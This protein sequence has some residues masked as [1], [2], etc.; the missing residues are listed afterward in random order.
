MPIARPV[1]WMDMPM[2]SG[3]SKRAVVIDGSSLTIDQVVGVARSRGEVSLG[4][5]AKKRMMSS[6][7][8]LE[9]LLEAGTTIYAVNTGV[10]DLVSSRIP[11]KDLKALQL[12][13]LRSHACGVG[14]PYPEEITRAIMLLRANALAKGYSGV[15]P[16]IADALLGML[17]AGIHP[18]IPR[19]GSVGASG[20][21]TMLAHL[22]LVL[23][24]EGFADSGHGME[25]GK[26]ALA[27]KGMKPLSLEAKEAISIINGTQAMTAIG[28][29]AVRDAANLADNAQI[30]A[31]LSLEAL[32]G[33]SAAFDPRISKVRAYPG[34]ARVAEN[35]ISLLDGS[36]IMLSHKHCSKVQDAYTLRCIPQV[37]GASLGAIWYAEDIVS[38]EINSATDNPLFFPEDSSVVSAGNFHGQPVALAMDF[39][40]LAVHEIGSFAERRVARMVDHKLS[41]LPAFLTRH[42]GLSSG[43]M[44]PQYVAASLVSENKVL[45]HPASASSIPTSANQEDHNS[46]GTIA[47]WKAR[48]ILA[49]STRIVAIEMLAA[50]QA[51][52]F[53]SASSSEV[54]EEVRASIREKVPPLNEDRSMT[55]DI[56]ALGEMIGAGV[57]ADIAEH[58]C[59]F[60][61]A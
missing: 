30:A 37:L 25:P 33:T 7:A 58:S 23:V 46:M 43:M 24:G 28:A 39:M 38:V 26:D 61:R 34:Q 21:L 44:V 2:T 54:L 47:A 31:A 4:D 1:H 40:G 32:K 13:L 20:D 60:R 27:R 15:R 50:A 10:G 53:V 45:V 56:E 3:E 16:D 6:R 42:G 48:Q 9:K 8:A 22:G 57:L 49:N 17:N 36:E 29:L 41:G 14:E 18:Q 11:K 19:Q 35:M 52:D 5:E 51:L 55:S 59:G 12:N